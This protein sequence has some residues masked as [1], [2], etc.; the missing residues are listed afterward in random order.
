MSVPGTGHETVGAWK[1]NIWSKE[2]D[3]R[4]NELIIASGPKVRWS[5]IGEQMVG[6]SGKQCRER[7]HNH[8]SP[9]VRARPAA[10]ETAQQILI[11][12]IHHAAA[13]ATLAGL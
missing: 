10:P 9:E 8:L 6:R 1:K 7:W 12:L 5:I 4:L 2:E 11:H 13:A 3:Q